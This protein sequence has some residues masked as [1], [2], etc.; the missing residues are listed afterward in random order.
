LS[1]ERNVYKQ[2]VMNILIS[3]LVA[4]IIM[5]IFSYTLFSKK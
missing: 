4:I 1:Q 5:I 2:K 3:S